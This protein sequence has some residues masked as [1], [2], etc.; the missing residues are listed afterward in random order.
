MIISRGLCTLRTFNTSSIL[1][2]HA[3][4]IYFRAL[5]PPLFNIQRLVADPLLL[6]SLNVHTKAFRTCHIFMNAPMSVSALVC[7]HSHTYLNIVPCII[8]FKACCP[9]LYSRCPA[10][11]LHTH[12]L[13]QH[14]PHI[15]KPSKSL[16]HPLL[17]SSNSSK[18]PQTFPVLPCQVK[19]CQLLT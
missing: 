18:T 4:T 9:F 12:R 6:Q 1:T 17:M 7:I 19:A 14:I 15:H 13:N 8:L 16:L 2:L 10:V 3:C 11:T 5:Q